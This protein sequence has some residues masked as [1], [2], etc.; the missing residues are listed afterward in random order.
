MSLKQFNVAY[1]KN[2]DRIMLSFNTVDHN[3]YKF[4]LTR[5]ITKFI[6]T[7]I[8]PYFEN[9]FKKQAPS[10]SNVISEL[11]QS[12]K[13]T[14]FN[15]PYEPGHKY[16]IGAEAILVMDI[17]ITMT[18]ANEH[19]FFSLDFLLPGGGNVNLKLSALIMKNLILLLEEQNLQAKW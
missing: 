5:R 7:S 17:K 3:E 6:L 12:N 4:W 10:I 8:D 9:N 19:D 2:E 14:T 11:Q 16:P 13:Q 1:F 18:K 15:K